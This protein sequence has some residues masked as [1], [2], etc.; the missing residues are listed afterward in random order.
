MWC[1]AEL[2]KMASEIKCTRKNRNE[3][4]KHSFDRSLID[5]LLSVIPLE[6]VSAVHIKMPKNYMAFAVYY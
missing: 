3:M 5:I 2:C 4:R 1:S 6:K